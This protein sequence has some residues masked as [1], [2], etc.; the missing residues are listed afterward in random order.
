MSIFSFK[1]TFASFRSMLDDAE[2]TFSEVNE[3]CAAGVTITNNNGHVVIVG[4]VKSLR[5]NDTSISLNP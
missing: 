4:P 1:E 2:K 5:V 3:Q